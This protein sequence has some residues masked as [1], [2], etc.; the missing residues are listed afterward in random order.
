MRLTLV[1]PS[2]ITIREREMENIENIREMEM[3]RALIT[4]RPKTGTILYIYICEL[5]LKYRHTY[6]RIYIKCM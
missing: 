6:L 5:N 3:A 2:I 1:S 4:A